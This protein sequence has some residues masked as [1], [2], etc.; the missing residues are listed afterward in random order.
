MSKSD[1]SINVD[2]NVKF[3]EED[4]KEIAE[5]VKVPLR[6]KPGVGRSGEGNLL[7]RFYKWTKIA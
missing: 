3:M 2:I 7:F 4:P 6:K 1:T 5:G